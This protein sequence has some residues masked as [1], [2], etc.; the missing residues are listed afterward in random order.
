MDYSCLPRRLCNKLE[1]ENMLS[2][3]Q[4]LATIL[5]CVDTDWWDYMHLCVRVPGTCNFVL[6]SWRTGT[7]SSIECCIAA[8]K[9]MAYRVCMYMYAQ[10][11]YSNCFFSVYAACVITS[12]KATKT[13]RNKKRLIVTSRLFLPQSNQNANV[14]SVRLVFIG[15]SQRNVIALTSQIQNRLL[16]IRVRSGVKYDE[17]GNKRYPHRR[18]I[19]R[20]RRRQSV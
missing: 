10:S 4:L 1:G 17:S 2:C 13:K 6:K 12:R 3:E 15:A 7:F 8:F 18:R 16:G 19:R 11:Y 20:R 9:T 14:L 5:A